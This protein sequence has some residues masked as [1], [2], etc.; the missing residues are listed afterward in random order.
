[1]K[2]ENPYL[3]ALP[4]ALIVGFGF[5]LNLLAA[6]VGSALL[7][8][9]VGFPIPVESVSAVLVRNVLLSITVGATVGFYVFRAW[10]TVTAKWVWILPALLFVVRFG[11][12]F[13]SL[14]QVSV[15]GMEGS[16]FH[17]LWIQLSG[18]GCYE[19]WRAWPCLN[20]DLFTIPL[21]STASYSVGA[22]IC[23]RR[24]R[25]YGVISVR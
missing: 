10:E 4:R 19:G 7:V 22:W 6:I 5:A 3:E 11:S 25:R 24:F 20:F 17:Q 16:R 14:P 1:M 15:F 21:I 9:L 13:L 18:A 2:T 8:V 23:E 12:F